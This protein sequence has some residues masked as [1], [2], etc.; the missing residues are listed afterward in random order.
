MSKGPSTY[1][2]FVCFVLFCVF[3]RTHGMQISAVSS[4][5][6]ISLLKR[7]F[8]GRKFPFHDVKSDGRNMRLRGRLLGEFQPGLKF[9]TV[10]RA[11][12]Y[13]ANFSPGAMFKIGRERLQ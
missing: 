12:I 8:K 6:R 3:S 5:M 11:E 2:F 4:L 10:H 1:V 13:M 9:R 7:K